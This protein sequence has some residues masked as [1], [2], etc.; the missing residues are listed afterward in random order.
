MPFKDEGFVF[1]FNKK[2]KCDKKQ[3]KIQEI[4]QENSYKIQN[5]CFKAAQLLQCYV[6]YMTHVEKL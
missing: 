4:K 6:T 5:S 3:T 1:N 2:F